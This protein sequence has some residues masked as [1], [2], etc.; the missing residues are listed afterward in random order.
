[1]LMFLLGF[2]VCGSIVAF[3]CSVFAAGLGGKAK[4]FWGVFVWTP[5]WPILLPLMVAGL[6][7]NVFGDMNRWKAK[8][9]VGSSPRSKQYDSQG[10]NSS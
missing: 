8:T 10:W 5:L 1:M 4:D 7:I 3:L 9:K 6:L 2:Y